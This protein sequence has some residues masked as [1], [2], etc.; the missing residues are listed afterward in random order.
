[1]TQYPTLRLL[2]RHG[3]WL[4]IIVAA[5][6]LIASVV[7]TVLGQSAWWILAGAGA[8][9]V[10]FIGARSYVE[11]VRLMTDMLLPK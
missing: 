10:L 2:E 8:A 9:G 3:A 4:A 7:A 5:T 1:M 6:P 11:M